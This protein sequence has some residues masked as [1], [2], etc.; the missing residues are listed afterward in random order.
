MFM[1]D[2]ESRLP[3]KPIQA[4]KIFSVAVAVLAAVATVTVAIPVVKPNAVEASIPNAVE[5]SVVSASDLQ[6]ETA[7]SASISDDHHSAGHELVKRGDTNYY[8]TDNWGR[9]TWAALNSVQTMAACS[10]MSNLFASKWDREHYLD[11]GWWTWSGVIH[12]ASGEAFTVTA[13]IR[14]GYVLS[15]AYVGQIAFEALRLPI[16]FE[17]MGNKVTVFNTGDNN[18]IAWGYVNASVRR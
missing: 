11:Q 3:I 8:E 6:L 7:K 12:I 10:A 14:D 15:A 17:K 16:R 1:L 18:S 13:R 9:W 4:M 2:E 5:A